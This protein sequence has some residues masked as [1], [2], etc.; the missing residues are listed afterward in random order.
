ML[1]VNS[2]P[3]DSLQNLKTFPSWNSGL[4]LASKELA[5]MLLVVTPRMGERDVVKL[6]QVGVP[7]ARVLFFFAIFLRSNATSSFPK[8]PI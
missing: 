2:M 8:R 6:Q 3:Q 1:N 5:S 7:D 4:L